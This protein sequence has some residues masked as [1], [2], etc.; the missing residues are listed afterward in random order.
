QT[1][2]EVPEDFQ[3]FILLMLN[4]G[5]TNSDVAAL[6]KMEVRLDEGRIIRQRSKTRRHANP[7]LVNYKLWPTTH[8]LLQKH[9]SEH[10]MFALT[11]RKGNP[12]G[13]SKLVTRNGETKE[14]VWT[15]IGRRYGLMKTKEPSKKTDKKPLPDKQLKFLR[16]TGSTKIKSQK[17]FRLLDSLYLGH[18]WA[19]VADKHYNAFDG[20]PYQPLDEAI[21]WLGG[22]FNLS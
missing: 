20:E 1:L 6:L 18:S 16:K 17:Q 19:T 3:L 15:S 11:N 12:L 21:D 2:A 7:P 5:F 4:C 10:P 8:Q 9:W 22:E 13:V 14:T